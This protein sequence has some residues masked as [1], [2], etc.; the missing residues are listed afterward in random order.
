MTP[1][2]R[3]NIILVGSA[4]SYRGIPLQ[5]AYC[6]AKHAVQGFADSLRTE[7]LHAGSRVTVCRVQLPAMNTP[8]FDWVRSRMPR[9]AQPVP[10]V[11]QPEVAARAIFHLARHPRRELYVGYPTYEA[12]IGNKIA[13]SLADDYLARTGVSSQQTSEAE[14]PGRPDN[15]YAPVDADVDHGAH[16]RFGDVAMPRSEILELDMHRGLAGAA[17]LGL[18]ASALALW[19]R[20]RRRA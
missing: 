14:D 4:L 3:G 6:A 12:I 13:P 9:K 7:L 2:D 8:Q 10:P 5:S 16:G 20:R 19:A 17:A 18:L 11:F 15:L 1:R